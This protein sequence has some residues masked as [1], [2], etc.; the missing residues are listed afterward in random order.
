MGSET[1]KRYRNGRKS[2]CVVLIRIQA[3]ATY[4]KNSAGD[5]GGGICIAKDCLLGVEAAARDGHENR[6][7]GQFVP[8]LYFPAGSGISAVRVILL[9]MLDRRICMQAYPSER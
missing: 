3:P 8:S 1:A 5:G 2:H 4:L 7:D 6:T 9:E